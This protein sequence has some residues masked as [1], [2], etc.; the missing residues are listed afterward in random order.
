[1]IKRSE[2]LEIGRLLKPHGVKGEITVELFG[3]IDMLALKCVIVDIDGIFVPFFVQSV[4]P[5]TTDTC[6]VKFDNLDSDTEVSMLSLKPL[7]ALKEEVEIDD[8]DNDDGFYAGDL[9]GFTAVN[10]NGETIGTIADI[11]DDTEN[12]LFI[13]ETG[14]GESLLV[15]VAA[16]FISDID[17]ENNI[18][19][20]DLPEGLSDL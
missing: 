13:I 5:K 4:R 18:V 7:Y 11:N 17:S 8:G 16:E 3:D 19:K 2:I 6:L 10:P 20:L 12:T 9:I 14:S 1:M 15:P